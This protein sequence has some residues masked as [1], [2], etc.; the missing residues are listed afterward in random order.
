MKKE[1]LQ[2][3]LEIM[4]E[5]MGAITQTDEWIRIQM[6]DPQIKKAQAALDLAIRNVSHFVPEEVYKPLEDSATN[7]V[8][9]YAD[10]AILYG[11]QVADAIHT[12]AS[13]PDALSQHILNRISTQRG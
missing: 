9:A 5:L 6:E 11:I 10:A 13:K 1:S 8:S 7:A 12:A 3:N 4:D 2:V